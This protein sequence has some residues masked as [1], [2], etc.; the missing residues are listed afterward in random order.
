MHDNRPKI[1]IAAIA[2]DNVANIEVCIF[3]FA[4]IL[5]I[6]KSKISIFKCHTARLK[7]INIDY[8]IDKEEVLQKLTN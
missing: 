5:N 7:T 6:Q 8:T 4:K 1:K 2:S 3:F